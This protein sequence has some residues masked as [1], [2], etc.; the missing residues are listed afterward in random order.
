ME[1]NLVPPD[2]FWAEEQG[3]NIRVNWYLPKDSLGSVTGSRDF[4]NWYVNDPE[5]SCVDIVGV[6][7]GMIDRTLKVGRVVLGS[8]SRAVVGRDPS[9]KMRAEIQIGR[10]TYAKE[11]DLGSRYTPGDEIPMV[12]IGQSR[13]DTL[14]TGISLAFHEGVVDTAFGKEPA[15]F[16]IDLQGYDGFHVWRG[17]KR[18]PILNPSDLEI[19][20]EM[21]FAWFNPSYGEFQI[22]SDDSGRLVISFI[23][24]NVFVGFTYYY[25]V[26]CFDKGYFNGNFQFNKKDNFIC[27]EFTCEADTCA[28]DPPDPD[29]PVKC[30]SAC[31]A[32]TMTVK[33]SADLK[34]IYAVPNPF[35]DGS[36]AGTSPF[37]AN[38]PDKSIKFFNM[39]KEADLKIYTLSGDLVWE[40]HHSSPSG[41]NGVASW[42]VKNKHD[43]PVFSGVYIY[44][45][46]SSDGS[47]S[48]GRI[49]VIR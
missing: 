12:L 47:Q 11:F 27:D 17:V 2:S 38:F 35:R 30:E 18:G 22:R 40:T 3:S 49:V 21:D 4:S 26:T 24:A 9:I 31:K 44:R 20:A 43:E 6:Y 13:R 16:K 28:V 23:D 45:C 36:S 19:I 32:I 14:Y 10:D 15:Y 33:T 7:S 34:A 39:P 25:A 42:N 48:Y 1:L 8:F 5:V 29:H 37:Y 46:E 41:Q